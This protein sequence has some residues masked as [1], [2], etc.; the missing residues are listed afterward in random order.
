MYRPATGC[1]CQQ[2]GTARCTALAGF[3]RWSSKRFALH[4][5]LE[6]V[7]SQATDL[8]PAQPDR[9]RAYMFII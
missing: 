4:L 6:P 7:F 2:S 3:E 9:G 8:D 5:I 1:V